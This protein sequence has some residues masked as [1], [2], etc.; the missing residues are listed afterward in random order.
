MANQHF[1]SLEA[2]KRLIKKYKD[3]KEKVD[4]SVGKKLL[5]TCESFDR[6]AFDTILAKPGCTGIRIYLG[7]DEADLVR[8]V[9][10][11]VNEKDEDILPSTISQGKGGDETTGEEIIENGIRCPE[12]CP[13][14]SDLNTL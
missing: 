13:P 3:H 2:G 5:P 4:K 1:I 14:A 10:V 9:I 6:A 12:I 7:M 11:G 8:L